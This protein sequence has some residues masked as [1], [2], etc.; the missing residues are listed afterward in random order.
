MLAKHQNRKRV[1]HGINPGGYILNPFT[2]D[3]LDLRR[4]FYD[5]IVVRVVRTIIMTGIRLG[6]RGL[7]LAGCR[8]RGNQTGLGYNK[9]AVNYNL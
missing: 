4:Q 8:Y 9:D 6:G 2:C 7:R 3:N 1:S 5:W